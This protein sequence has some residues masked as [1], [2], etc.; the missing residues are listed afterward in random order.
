MREYNRI[1]DT[2][3]TEA[4]CLALIHQFVG[5]RWVRTEGVLVAKD[6]VM[7]QAVRAAKT[8]IIRT[9]MAQ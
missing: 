1:D 4:E 5:L 3:L 2:G 9:R 8:E 7:A 6:W